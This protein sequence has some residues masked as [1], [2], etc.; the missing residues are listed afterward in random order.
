MFFEI[1][2]NWKTSYNT[3]CSPAALKQN[4]NVSRGYEKNWCGGNIFDWPMS[5]P[6]YTL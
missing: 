3:S 5:Q 2:L 1:I 6:G 4:D